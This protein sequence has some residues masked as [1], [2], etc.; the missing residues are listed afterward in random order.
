MIK[1]KKAFSALGKIFN[2]LLLAI[3]VT[4]IA[5]LAYLLLGAKGKSLPFLEDYQ[6]RTVMSGSMEPTLPVGSV[7]LIREQDPS[8]FVEGDIMTFMSNDPSLAGKVVS[9]RVMEVIDN[10]N[11]GLMFL[12]KGDANED[13]DLAAAIAPN[14]I[15]RVVYD[16]PYLGY[17]LNFMRTKNGFFLLLMLPC[18]VIL[19]FEVIGLIRNIRLYCEEKEQLRLSKAQGERASAEEAERETSNAAN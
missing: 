10:E 7:V 5:A 18:M 3:L 4:A 9:H 11:N 12:T 19:L 8:A 15:G 16:I 6:I 2:V 1:V 13:P 17:V 14:V